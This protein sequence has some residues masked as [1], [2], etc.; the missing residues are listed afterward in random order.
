MQIFLKIELWKRYCKQLFLL[1]FFAIFVLSLSYIYFMNLA[2]LKTAERN[3]NLMELSEVK[4]EL[5][6]LEENYIAKLDKLDISHAKTM[7]FIEAEPTGYIYRDKI[8]V[9]GGYDSRVR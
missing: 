6:A 2:V 9:Q 8:V 1:L 3:I 5:Q 4:S 7:G